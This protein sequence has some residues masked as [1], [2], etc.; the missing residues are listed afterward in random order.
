MESGNA[1][2]AGR[3]GPIDILHYGSD[4]SSMNYKRDNAVLLKTSTKVNVQEL[5]RLVEG[6]LIESGY[7]PDEI[8]IQII[9]V[10]RSIPISK[11]LRL[12]VA[13][14]QPPRWILTR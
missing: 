12:I 8:D 10:D 9:Q 6:A 4:H 1:K 14:L 2:L 5:V 3:N 7:E 11:R 13:K